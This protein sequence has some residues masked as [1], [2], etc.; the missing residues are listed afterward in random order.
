MKKNILV[1]DD[2]ESIRFILKNILQ[3]DYNVETC[4][5][6]NQGLIYLQN[7]NIPDLIILDLVM[8]EIDGFDF[9][10]NIKKSTYFNSIPIIVLSAK[11]NSVE[12]V[13]CLKLGADDY[14]VKPFN[15]EEL[16]LRTLSLFKRAKLI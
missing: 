13:K 11:E 8:P 12:K 15:P 14:I 3:K 2:D 6:G 4:E 10:K 1:I 9:L 5:N 16:L 7:G